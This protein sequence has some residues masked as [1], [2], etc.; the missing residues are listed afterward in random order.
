MWENSW[1]KHD[2]ILVTIK[3][4]WWVY[5]SSFSL[6]WVCLKNAVNS[7]GQGVACCQ[8]H[9]PFS[10]K[11]L[12]KSKCTR[13]N[14]KSLWRTENYNQNYLSFLSQ[15]YLDPNTG[16]ASTAIWTADLSHHPPTKRDIM[17]IMEGELAILCMKYN[18]GNIGLKPS[19]LLNVPG[20]L[21]SASHSRQAG[22]VSTNY[23][24]QVQ[25]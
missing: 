15:K 14:W 23:F 9:L 12:R 24:R 21:I 1:N 6:S 18:R 8:G 7:K 5:E 19:L 25:S 4:A 20:K 16:S 13:S 17:A 2:K 22:I 3:S 10:P 11:T